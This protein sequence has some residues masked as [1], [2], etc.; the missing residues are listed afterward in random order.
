[1]RTVEGDRGEA[2]LR[3]A[4]RELTRRV[5]VFEVNQAIMS[6]KYGLLEKADQELRPG[7]RIS[8]ISHGEGSYVS[9][10]RKRIGA[11]RHTI[12]FDASGRQVVRLKGLCWGVEGDVLRG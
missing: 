11:N 2:R 12:D 4:V 10:K 5:A 8:L 3:D 7:T 9:F 1:M 6:R